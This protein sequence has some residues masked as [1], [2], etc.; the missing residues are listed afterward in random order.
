MSEYHPAEQ[1]IAALNACCTG[2]FNEG[3][4]VAL[5]FNLDDLMQTLS[6]CAGL[7]I[8]VAG[9]EGVKPAEVLRDMSLRAAEIA[10]RSRASR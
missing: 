7:V 5:T 3:V 9:H 1:F 6:A 8:R 10:A 4:K 2:D